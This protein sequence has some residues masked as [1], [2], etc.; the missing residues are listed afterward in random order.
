[1]KSS[2]REQTKF[3]TDHKILEVLLLTRII[4]HGY[5]GYMTCFYVIYIS[6][7]EFHTVDIPQLADVVQYCKVEKSFLQIGAQFH[8]AKV[9]AVMVFFKFSNKVSCLVCR[10]YW[11]HF[12]IH[13]SG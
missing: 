13:W 6:H 7:L 12:F 5:R 1:M 4:S 8:S 3:S 2:Q 10:C 11:H 9:Q